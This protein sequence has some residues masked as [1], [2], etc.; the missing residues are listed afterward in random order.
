MTDAFTPHS[1][2]L[3]PEPPMATA[4]SEPALNFL[5]G[6][7][8]RAVIAERMEQIEAHGHL[9][10]TD[11][12]YQQGELALAAKSYLD[13]YIDLETREYQ[14]PTSLPDSW[15]FGDMF[16]K[17]PTYEQRAHALVKAL[18]LGLAE[19]DRLKAAID[20]SRAARPLID[21]PPVSPSPDAT[22]LHELDWH[23]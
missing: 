21:Y 3:T 6:P 15:P 1:L 13:T 7:A 23:G 10:D 11:M 8:L 5:T 16:W 20:L 19:L 17:E 9:P 22:P 18:A 12:G 4:N 2:R 14:A